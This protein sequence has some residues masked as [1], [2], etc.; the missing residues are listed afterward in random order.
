MYVCMY[1]CM[2]I[3]MY[4]CIMYVCMYVCM[5]AVTAAFGCRRWFIF[6]SYIKVIVSDC[7]ASSGSFQIFP[8]GYR[9]PECKARLHV[10]L[11]GCTSSINASV[12]NLN[13]RLACGY[14]TVGFIK[15]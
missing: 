13:V 3:C 8:R 4:I 5:C 7:W 12:A 1:V 10:V 14:H 6:L 15:F 11:L 2:H 9:R